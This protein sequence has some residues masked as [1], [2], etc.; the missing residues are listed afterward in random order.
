MNN[1]FLLTKSSFLSGF[2]TNKKKNNQSSAFKMMAIVGVIFL[3]LSSFYSFMFIQMVD[4]ENPKQYDYFLVSVLTITALMS[5]ILSIFQMQSQIFK[6][7]D[8]EFLESLPITNKTIVASKIASVYLM[9]LF[10]D[11]LIALPS[12][13][14]Y[15]IYTGNIYGFIL[16][17]IS[18]FF[19]SLIPLLLSS[20]I[21]TIVAILSARSKHKT[22][23]TIL[24]YIVFF[25]LV[26]TLSFTISF[27]MTALEEA[28][29]A[30]DLEPF[31]SK[32]PY[33][34]L[35]KNAFEISN[36]WQF[37]I[38]ILIHLVSFALVVLFISSLYRRINSIES[39]KE[40]EEYKETGEKTVNTKTNYLL[41]KEVKSVLKRP[42]Y[43]MNS[44]SGVLVYFMLSILFL[45]I[46]SSVI[47]NIEGEDT[48]DMLL[49]M[50]MFVFMVPAM[51]I[52]GNT[53]S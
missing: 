28:G 6:T 42:N 7:K 2:N 21:G 52:M 9:N 37:I 5:I 51:G 25:T 27:K 33:F 43:L 38:F 36:F 34:V 29:Q 46:E 4:T 18:L 22:I 47:G 44:F 17:F 24:A 11:S 19:V 50:K 45:F 41:K 32:I 31:A 39:A 10:E 12:L 16:G 40:H 35:L 15:I 30:L 53:M 26:M 1:F 20:L 23:I 49:M 48:S 8:Y 3:L 14:L 13:V